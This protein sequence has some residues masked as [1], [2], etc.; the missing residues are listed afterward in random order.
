[1]RILALDSSG[2]VAGV[3]V[4]YADEKEEQL[5]AEYTVNF[6]KTHSQ[7][8][9]PML[10]E[11]A[12]MTELDMESIDAIAVAAGPGSFTGLRIGS[13]TAKGLGL[14]LNKPLVAVPTL[15]GLAYNL[16][17]AADIVCPIMDA[18]RGQ[19]YA[20]I[21]EFHKNKLIV[22]EDQMAIAIEELGR[23]LLDYDRRI[24]FL[25][26][27][28]PVFRDVL[29]EQLLKGRDISF[30]PCNMNRQRAASV[31]ALAICYYRDGKIESALEHVPE[32]LRV[33]QAEREQ[34]ERQEQQ[35][36]MR[37]GL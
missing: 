13:A 18:R 21:Y 35:K 32:Y 15:E 19:V 20:G 4:A 33:S 30:A 6:K 36:R 2:L 14:A 3:A 23:K 16:C 7:T 11:V 8:L 1:M 34:K 10:D 27:G 24:I 17:G 12:K 25:G 37:D 9:L 28:V 29:T 26:D 31:A 5:V 22:L